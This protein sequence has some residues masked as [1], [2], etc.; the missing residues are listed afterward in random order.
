MLNVSSV[1]VNILI[2][3]AWTDAMLSARGLLKRRSE[4][5]TV[6]T[7]TNIVQNA[8]GRTFKV[9]RINLANQMHAVIMLK[10]ACL[11]AGPVCAAD[12]AHLPRS[13]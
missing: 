2:V 3:P 5:I 4:K 1:V 7:M 10:C 13:F 6:Q 12:Q 9:R 8:T 11:H